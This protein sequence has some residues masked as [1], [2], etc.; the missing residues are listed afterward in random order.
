MR[1]RKGFK[2]QFTDYM[3]VN[4]GFGGTNTDPATGIHYGV[5]S[6]N[7]LHEWAW[8]SLE[9]DYGTPTCPKCGGTVYE[10]GDD[11]LTAALQAAG[12]TEEQIDNFTPKRDYFCVACR[13]SFDSDRVFGEEPLGHY[14]D[15][16]EYSGTVGSDNDLMLVRSPY[17][18]HTQYCSPCAPGAGHLEH[19]FDREWVYDLRLRCLREER[20]GVRA[21]C[22]GGDWFDQDRPPYHVYAA[23]S[24]VLV[25]A[26]GHV[27]EGG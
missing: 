15:N 12:W 5:I 1:R 21:Y 14:I 8:E 26:A 19:P 24:G 23:A 10:N 3:G 11:K 27:W 9:P 13:K 17:Y 6:V 4:Y 7:A 2:P 22:L 20:P 18:T 16:A 25:C